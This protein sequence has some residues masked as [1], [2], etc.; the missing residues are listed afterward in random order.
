[1]DRWDAYAK[2]AKNNKHKPYIDEGLSCIVHSRSSSICM[3]KVAKY[4]KHELHRYTKRVVPLNTTIEPSH[5]EDYTEVLSTTDILEFN[6]KPSTRELDVLELLR[7]GYTTAE[8]GVMLG[9]STQ[10][11]NTYLKRLRKKVVL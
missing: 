8:V 5:T 6:I 3:Y 11:V 10:S 2:Y 1:M 7:Y 9:I 4:A